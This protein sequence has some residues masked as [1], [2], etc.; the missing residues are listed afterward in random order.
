MRPRRRARLRDKGLDLGAAA[1][2]RL[3]GSWLSSEHSALS[4]PPAR[5]R[6][7]TPPPPP[8]SQ[9]PR[10]QGAEFRGSSRPLGGRG[11]PG[12][13]PREGAPSARPSRPD[14]RAPAPAAPQPRRGVRSGRQCA[15]RPGAAN[16][17]ALAPRR[18]RRGR[19]C[20]GGAPQW[21]GPGR[22]VRGVAGRGEGG[23]AAAP[24]GGGGGL[25][26][27]RATREH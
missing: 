17:R 20:P 24:G 21:L 14:R 12:T 19:R 23:S 1:E 11:G 5:P 22:Q 8:P 15:A 25:S 27:F 10:E 4:V 7:P 3:E 9:K 6:Y 26:C 13:R 2:G 16:T 18:R